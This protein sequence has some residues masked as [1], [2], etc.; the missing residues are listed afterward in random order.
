MKTNHAEKDEKALNSSHDDHDSCPNC[1]QLT[2]FSLL[3]NYYI[4]FDVDCC[5]FSLLYRHKVHPK[6]KGQATK[7]DEKYT[8][9][10]VRIPRKDAEGFETAM[11]ELPGKMY[12]CGHS[13]YESFCR[14]TMTE[15]DEFEAEHAKK[16]SWIVTA[17]KKVLPARLWGV[18][19]T[20]E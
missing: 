14:Q 7:P 2:K 17:I 19:P 3:Y 8:M 12:L 6:F 10:M 1:V 9:L 15:L 16:E 5:S 18:S 11:E 4:Y 13:N 20:V